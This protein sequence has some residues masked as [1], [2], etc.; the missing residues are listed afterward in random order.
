MKA[1]RDIEGRIK[2]IAIDDVF[3]NVEDI[4]QCPL[5]HIYYHKCLEQDYEPDSRKDSQQDG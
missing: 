1:V 5:L 3:F 2:G 4:Y